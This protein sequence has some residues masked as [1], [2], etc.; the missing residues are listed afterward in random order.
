MIIMMAMMVVIVVLKIVILIMVPDHAKMNMMINS[1][2]NCSHTQ[3]QRRNNKHAEL[4]TQ[5]TDIEKVP[6]PRSDNPDTQI[7]QS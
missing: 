6:T 5:G 7:T 4:I 3:S 1:Y 2:K